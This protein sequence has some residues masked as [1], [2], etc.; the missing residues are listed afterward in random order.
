[1][2]HIL[3]S[4][5]NPSLVG[6]SLATVTQFIFPPPHLGTDST[7]ELCLFWDLGP[8]C[9]RLVGHLIPPGIPTLLLSQGPALGERNTAERPG[10][11]WE[12]HK[13]YK[14]SAP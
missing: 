7:Q 11:V 13:R 1:M 6:P 9:K 12:G 14:L 5:G 2:P 3:P 8:D 4:P 10:R